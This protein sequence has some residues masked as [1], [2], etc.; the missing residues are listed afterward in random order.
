MSAATVTLAIF[1]LDIG[2]MIFQRCR[3][4]VRRDGIDYC[5]RWEK[6]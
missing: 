6:I 2:A 3:V 5:L 1:V 4:V